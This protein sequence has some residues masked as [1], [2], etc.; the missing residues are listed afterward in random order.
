MPGIHAPGARERPWRQ[1][2]VVGDAHDHRAERRF[3]GRQKV[4][5]ARPCRNRE[6]R[7]GIRDAHRNALGGRRVVGAR[8]HEDGAR[9]G[10]RERSA[11]RGRGPGGEQS[12]GKEQQSTAASG[13]LGQ[14]PHRDPSLL[15]FCRIRT[16]E[17]GRTVRFLHLRRP[18]RVGAYATVTRGF[19]ARLSPL[20]PTE[21][22]TFTVGVCRAWIHRGQRSPGATSG[23]RSREMGVA[24]GVRPARVAPIAPAA[25]L[26]CPRSAIRRSMPSPSGSL[27]RTAMRIGTSARAS[28]DGGTWITCRE[29]SHTIRC[30]KASGRRTVATRRNL[31]VDAATGDSDSLR[32][33]Q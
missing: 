24:A 22:A 1:A 30:K 13:E 3:H 11:R 31:G 7:R 5:G 23:L 25:F 21:P 9:R 33:R 16:R 29:Q 28:R 26:A 27:A 20:R 32:A 10:W 2:G 6:H 17:P 18:G 8:I 12:G 4:E 14:N 15:R 19:E